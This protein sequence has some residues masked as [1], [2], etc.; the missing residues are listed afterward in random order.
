MD[1]IME[2][3]VYTDE[4][5]AGLELMWGQGFL[6]PGGEEEVALIVNG[7][8]LKDKAILDIGSGIGGP[9]IC[10]ASKHGADRIVGIDLEPLNVERATLR[11]T[12]AGVADRATFQAVEG[13]ALPF[14]DGSFD[15]VFSKDAII[16]APNKADLMRE[17]YRVLRPGGW[18][19]LSDWFRGSEPFTAEMTQF[20]KDAGPTLRM[21]T[22]DDTAT[23][24][25][26]AGFVEIAASD[27]NA[28]YQDYTKKELE[29]M[30]GENLVR[31]EAVLGKDETAKWIATVTSKC[32]A[33]EQGQLRPGH[34]RAQRP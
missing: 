10:L 26:E 14:D 29:R 12:N 9:A 28:W 8:G 23:L 32:V 21:A 16:E 31:F 33:V 11:S 6:S 30:T 24:L 22:L 17:A 5:V 1:V 3:T 25:R 19:A 34:L 20:L 4:L 13:V 18:I 15:I 27:R 2:E 7:L